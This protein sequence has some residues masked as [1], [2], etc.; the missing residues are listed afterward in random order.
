MNQQ[1]TQALILS[2][3]RQEIDE[4]TV[5]LTRAFM[6]LEEAG[7]SPAQIE[8]LREIMRLLHT[9]KGAARMVGFP[10]I[11]RVAHVMEELVGYFR[12][13]QPP[14]EVPRPTIDLLFDGLDT[15]GEMMKEATRPG[16]PPEEPGFLTVP[17]VVEALVGKMAV[18][19][20]KPELAFEQAEAK[21]NGNG[22]GLN[23]GNGNGHNNGNGHS[24]GNSN[25]NGV[26]HEL[27]LPDESG[28]IIY[29]TA[30]AAPANYAPA[31]DGTESRGGEETIRV[32]LSKL[33]DLINLAGELVINKQQNEEHLQALQEL[34]RQARTRSR[35]AQ[36]LRDYLIERVPVE[37]RSRLLGITELFSF[38]QPQMP[39]WIKQDGSKNA[40]NGH[41]H[42]GN[43]HSHNGNGHGSSFSALLAPE[44]G[45][46][47]KPGTGEKFKEDPLGLKK[48]FGKIEEMITFDSELERQLATVLRERKAYNL[49]FGAAADELRRNMLGIRML[50]LDTIFARFA[51]PIRDLAYE[52]GKE[53]KLVVVGGAIEVDKRILEQISDPLIHM[54]RNAIDHGLEK[55]DER[56]Q[57][58]KS[59]EGVLRLTA[60][61]K[62]SHVLI[63]VID[64]GRGI[65]PQNLREIAIK[66][67]YMDAATAN[68]LSDEAALDLIYRAGFSTRTQ[69]DEV[70]GRG[71]GM[72]VVQQHIKRL[73]GRILVQ[74]VQ[75]QGTTFSMEIPLTLATVDALIVRSAGQLFAMPSVMVAGTLRS[76]RE[77]LQSVEG[78]PVMRL[79]GQLVPVVKMSDVL[80]IANP[81]P[82]EDE[83]DQTP[84]EDQD[85]FSAVLLSAGTGAGPTQEAS[86]RFICFEVDALVDE[87]EVVVKGLGSFLDKV[88]NIAGVTVL[89]ADGLALILDVFGLIQSARLGSS[90][91]ISYTP[92]YS[93]PSSDSA[94]LLARKVQR[95]LVVDDSLATR[96]LERSILETAGFKVDTARDGLEALK[97]CRE[98]KPDLV[99]SDVEMPNM[100]G[101]RLTASIR[102]DE[103][104]NSLPVIIVSS[105]DSEE[106]RRKGLEAGAQAYIVKGQFEQNKLLETISRLIV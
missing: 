11:A 9:V 23:H 54:L 102:Q 47:S 92:K 80:A 87:R 74:S 48:I 28:Q 101:F 99:L 51:R 78:H 40:T 44:W 97:M 86:E 57:A 96:E 100:D 89:G 81:A 73:N 69:A 19:A 65:D 38:E 88:P 83:A 17:E 77:G 106:D 8:K 91:A 4:H 71:V 2:T 58:G 46:S 79:R 29:R 15:I 27:E 12:E 43:G 64:D 103:R 31:Q 16:G 5:N 95:I 26:H 25:G 85:Y 60:L 37:E 61:Q 36:Q 34:M 70:S 42:N 93:A 94:T 90:G 76:S 1:E 84:A 50:P 59:P 67:G 49:R 7:T 75:G 41:S 104:L 13:C 32:R 10:T 39:D 98:R 72:D 18:L 82:S 24:N 21:R 56:V 22:N 66:K 30:E 62:G 35:V 3:F 105:R 55:P 68:S 52:C 33:D 20:G 63:Q 14:Q 6:E 53:V 45:G